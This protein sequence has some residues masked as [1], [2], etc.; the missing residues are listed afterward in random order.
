MK[1]VPNRANEKCHVGVIENV[2]K[3]A[4]EKCRVSENE[5]RT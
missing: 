5:K 1:N 3:R 2:P 4:N